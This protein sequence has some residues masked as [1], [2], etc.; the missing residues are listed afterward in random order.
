MLHEQV[1]RDFSS[2]VALRKAEHVH[3]S[4]AAV[5]A[6]VGAEALLDAVAVVAAFATKTRLVDV[7]GM[8]HSWQGKAVVDHI[9]KSKP[10]GLKGLVGLGLLHFWT[11]NLRKKTSES[12]L[13]VKEKKGKT[14]YEASE[15]NLEEKALIADKM[16]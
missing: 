10:T 15:R 2:D 9:G 12:V 8:G 1:L 7:T 5:E 6:A 3:S 14:Q 16:E 4:K 13:V 11:R